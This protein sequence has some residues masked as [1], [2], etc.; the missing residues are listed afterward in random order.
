MRYDAEHKQKTRSKVLEVAAKAIR[1]DGP[2]R[3]G[4]AGVMAEAGLTHG[5][6]YAHFKSKDDLVTAAIEQ[7]F[8]ESRARLKHEMEG[9]APAQGL[10]N[11]IDFYLS[12][13]HRD[14]R[15]S[16]CPMAA[17]ASDLPR[18]PEQ[19]RELFADGARRLTDA[20]AERFTALGY[21]DP[22]TLAR[23]TVS[24]LVGALSLA[25]VETDAKRSDAILAD[26]RHLLKQRLGLESAP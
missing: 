9:H 6:F 26:S 24:E 25:R 19:T 14:A 4:V 13:K 2:D 8:E 11:Y 18:L 17:L 21:S 1:Q 3:I 20:M 7:M 12:K 23:S 16:G 10:A 15:S 22:Q 5:G